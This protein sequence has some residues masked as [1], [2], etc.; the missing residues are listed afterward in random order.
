MLYSK[1]RTFSSV[2]VFVLDDLGYGFFLDLSLVVHVLKFFV[3]GAEGKNCFK[4]RKL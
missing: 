2:G 1:I 4:Q 3:S